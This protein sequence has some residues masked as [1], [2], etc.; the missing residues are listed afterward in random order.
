MAEDPGPPDSFVV[1]LARSGRQVRVAADTTILQ[2]LLAV[3]PVDFQCLRG[4]CGTCVQR[5][6]AGTPAHRD[7]VLSPRAKAAN[8]RIAI[9]VSR[10]RTPV[11]VLDL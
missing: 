8:K 10:S 5:V 1:E 6:V 9:C 3:E 11:L 7:T 2:A 4:E